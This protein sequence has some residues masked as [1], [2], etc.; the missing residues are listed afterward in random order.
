[1]IIT[2]AAAIAALA[3]RVLYFG[4][5]QIRRVETNDVKARAEDIEW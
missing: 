3:D 4:D 5:C 1:M 2:H